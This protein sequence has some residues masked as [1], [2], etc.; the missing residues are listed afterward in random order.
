MKPTNTDDIWWILEHLE[1][2]KITTEYEIVFFIFFQLHDE[3]EINEIRRKEK[4]R[5]FFF[6]NF[7]F[8]QFIIGCLFYFDLLSN[9]QFTVVFFFFL[10]IIYLTMFER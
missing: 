8:I 7:I 5:A 6:V 3:H 2:V 4:K 1:T 9:L 10:Y